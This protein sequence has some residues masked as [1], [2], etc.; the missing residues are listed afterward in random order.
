MK[1]L[2]SVTLRPFVKSMVLEGPV[3]WQGAECHFTLASLQNSRPKNL[4]KNNNFP[5][6]PTIWIPNFGKAQSE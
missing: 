1:N 3:N 4:S 2:Q 6:R 5:N